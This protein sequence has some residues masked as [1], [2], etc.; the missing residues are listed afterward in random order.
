[1]EEAAAK[2]DGHGAIRCASA[3]EERMTVSVIIGECPSP[4]PRLPRDTTSKCLDEIIW[5][6]HLRRYAGEDIVHGAGKSRWEL[7][8]QRAWIPSIHNG[9]IMVEKPFGISLVDH[10]ELDGHRIEVQACEIDGELWQEEMMEE[11]GS[12]GTEEL[13]CLEMVEGGDE[14][15]GCEGVMVVK[16]RCGAGGRCPFEEKE[17]GDGS[18]PSVNKWSATAGREKEDDRRKEKLWIRRRKLEEKRRLHIINSMS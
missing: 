18:P 8:V 13:T 4:P 9:H 3:P 5:K 16:T 1:M 6:I 15:D 12:G 17:K 14:F 7:Q 2:H 11:D 10:Y